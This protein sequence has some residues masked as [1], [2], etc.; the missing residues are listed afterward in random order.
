MEP[1]VAALPASK[2]PDRRELGMSR[3]RPAGTGNVNGRAQRSQYRF[4]VRV[5]SGKTP[6]KLTRE[7]WLLVPDESTR[8]SASDVEA[9]VMRIFGF[10]IERSRRCA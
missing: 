6:E 3:W 9:A 1:G 7:G 5:T 4:A 8:A 2:H 10:G